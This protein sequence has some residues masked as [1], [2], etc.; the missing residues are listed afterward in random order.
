[1]SDKERDEVWRHMK[2]GGKCFSHYEFADIMRNLVRRTVTR[3]L[4]PVHLARQ[5]RKTLFAP[6]RR[7]A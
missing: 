4:C 2:M 5:I 7:R 6:A 1:M 3:E